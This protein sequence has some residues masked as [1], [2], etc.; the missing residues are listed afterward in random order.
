MADLWFLCVDND[1]GYYIGDGSFLSAS[2]GQPEL[3][4]KLA[5][6]GSTVV[7][8]DVSISI[9]DTIVGIVPGNFVKPFLESNMMQADFH[10]NFN[11]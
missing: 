2:S 8:S 9:K 3:A 6:D 5:A 11:R 10:G 1:I 4:S 7:S